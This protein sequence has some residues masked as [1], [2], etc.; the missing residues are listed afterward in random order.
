VLAL[1]LHRRS[2]LDQALAAWQREPRLPPLHI[3]GVDQGEV[4]VADW[5]RRVRA[6]PALRDRVLLIGPAWGVAREDLLDRASVWLAPYPVDRDT[7]HRLCPLQVADAAGSGLPLV[8]SDLPSIRAMLPGAPAG[9]AAP[10]DPSA[11][12]ARVLEA[13]SAPRPAWSPR[14][15]WADRADRLLEACP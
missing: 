10:D 9:Y 6:D 7:A 4:R 14:P 12:A 11:L 2:G 8:T 15:G 3:A 13:L 5:W 1:G